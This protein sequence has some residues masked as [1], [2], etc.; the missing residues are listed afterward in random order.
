MRRGQP[1]LVAAV[2]S[3]DKVMGLAGG[4]EEGF[5]GYVCRPAIERR[6]RSHFASSAISTA[7]RRMAG[8]SATLSRIA[9]AAPS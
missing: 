7:M 5:D 9:A 6:R 4:R 2:L 8:N 3:A 1:G